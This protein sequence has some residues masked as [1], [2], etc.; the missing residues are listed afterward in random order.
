M[1]PSPS[2]RTKVLIAKRFCGAVA[3][4]ENSRSPSIA[5]PNVL[6]M[7]VAVKVRIST[8]ARK[9]LSASF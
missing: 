5:I 6:G 3:I 2:R 8:S 7:G 9:A 1:T 4:M